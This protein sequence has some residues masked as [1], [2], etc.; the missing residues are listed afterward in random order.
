MTG[1]RGQLS[2]AEFFRGGGVAPT[3]ALPQRGRGREITG[4]IG[5][6]R[7]PGGR[8]QLLKQEFFCAVAG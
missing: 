4:Q 7:L 6:Q 8:E 1:V 2:I 3:L 5:L